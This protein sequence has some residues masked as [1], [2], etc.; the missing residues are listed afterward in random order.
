MDKEVYTDEYY[1][2]L[3]D[4]GRIRATSFRYFLAYPIY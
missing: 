3:S 2:L 4:L 1:E